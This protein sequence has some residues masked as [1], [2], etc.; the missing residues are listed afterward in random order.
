MHAYRIILLSC[1]LS[2]AGLL[3]TAALAAYLPDESQRAGLDLRLETVGKP[4]PVGMMLQVGKPYQPGQAAY[5]YKFGD[6]SLHWRLE[7][8][9]P[10]PGGAYHVFLWRF[11]PDRANRGDY[12]IRGGRVDMR[13]FEEPMDTASRD[14][15][16][17]SEL[18]IGLLLTGEPNR[19]PFPEH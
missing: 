10:L 9:E 12:V 1:S 3:T 16:A 4:S 11:Y 2:L 13:E 15:V 18:A 6:G 5:L 17:K 19:D 8:W 14:V 7:E